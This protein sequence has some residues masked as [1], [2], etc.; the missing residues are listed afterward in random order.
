MLQIDKNSQTILDIVLAQLM[1]KE[2]T[3]L[4]IVPA[5]VLSFRGKNEKSC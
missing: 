3:I 5:C 2:K 1:D 4:L